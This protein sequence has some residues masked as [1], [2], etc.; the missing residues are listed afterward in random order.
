M[1]NTR[2]LVIGA[3]AAVLVVAFVLLRPGG[4]DETQPT[5]ATSPTIAPSPSDG[6]DAGSS[7]AGATPTDGSD[8]STGDGSGTSHEDPVVFEVKDGKVTGPKQVVIEQ[9]DVLHAWV[10]ADAA[11]E[12]HVHGFDLHFDVVPG[13]PTHVE[14]AGTAAG[15]YEVE[16]EE[17]G[18][19][20]FTLKVTA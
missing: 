2:W 8:D 11:D 7:D 9:G 15:I 16:L 17:A 6:H 10:T 4:D 3:A 12:V 20:L 1:R 18:L 14:V 19:L 13:E 5:A